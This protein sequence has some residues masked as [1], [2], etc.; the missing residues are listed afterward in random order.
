MGGNENTISGA[1]LSALG[2]FSDQLWLIVPVGLAI[3]I[4]VMW[5]IPKAK[6]FVKKVSG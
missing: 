5:A 1:I 4:G 6:S 2:D 3:G